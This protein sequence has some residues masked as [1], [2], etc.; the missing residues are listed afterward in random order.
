MKFNVFVQLKR[1]NLFTEIDGGWE[2]QKFLE[3]MFYL[4]K[5]Q[6]FYIKIE[7]LKGEKLIKKSKN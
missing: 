6:I 3:N 1:D 7:E 4:F 5:K 2:L